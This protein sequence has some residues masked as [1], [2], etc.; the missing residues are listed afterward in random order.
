M[1]DDK[2]F[3]DMNI[4]FVFEPKVLL[5]LFW[6][7]VISNLFIGFSGGNLIYVSLFLEILS[8]L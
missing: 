6:D 2:A 4:F 1:S 3:S 5:G 7:S 8:V